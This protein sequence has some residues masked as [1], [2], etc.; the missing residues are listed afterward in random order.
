M[1]QVYPDYYNKFKCIA[2]KCNHNCCIGWEIDI[3]NDT[4][5]KYKNHTETFGKKLKNNIKIKDGTPCFI[6]NADD[7]CPFLNKNNLCEIIINCGKD[8]LCEICSQHPRFHNYY[9]NVTESG[10]GL[11]C[12][13]AARII[14]TSNKKTKLIGKQDYNEFYFGCREN[15]FKI[16]QN[17]DLSIFERIEKIFEF[18]N[19]KITSIEVVK[20][21]EIFKQLEKLNDKWSEILDTALIYK[22]GTKKFIED[23]PI[24]FEQLFVYFLYRYTPKAIFE[25]LNEELVV[26]SVLCSVM[27]FYISFINGKTTIDELCDIA[28]MFSSENEY[29]DENI[30]KIFGKI[31]DLYF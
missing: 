2:Q 29:S 30:D 25:M 10:I 9:E 8:L 18:S 28:R 5:L 16:I 24:V 23:N 31:S 27:I 26:F 7:R 6:L 12:E 19:I 17:R 20:W 15:L 11:C 22:Q 14:L 21:I 4:Y 1:K 13:E 3:D